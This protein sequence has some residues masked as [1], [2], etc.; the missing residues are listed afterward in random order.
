M[1]LDIFFKGWY[2]EQNSGKEN[3]P[4]Q[5]ILFGTKSRVGNGNLFRKNSAELVSERFSLFHGI[6]C[7]FRGIP[8]SGKGPIPKLGTERNGIPRKK[9]VYTTAENLINKMICPYMGKSCFSYTIFWN[10]WLPR[11]V[12][13]G[14]SCTE[15]IG[16]GIPRVCFFFVSMEFRVLFS[17]AEWF[18]TE[19]GKSIFAP[20]NEI[21][22]C[23]FF[24]RRVQDGIKGGCFY[25]CSLERN[26]ESFRF[27]VTSSIPSE[28]TICSVYFVF[29][30]IIFL[31][32]ISNST[33]CI[34]T[35]VTTVYCYFNNYFQLC[36]VD[37]GYFLPL[38][39]RHPI[40]TICIVI[41]ILIHCLVSKFYHQF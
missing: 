25:F 41:F 9:L 11:F 12:S 20:Q 39:E 7:S 30:G 1:S 21:P 31:S 23:F 26:S 16:N 19:F 13:V 3:L 28:I 40:Q 10:F 35:Q 4:K 15:W 27:R 22:S 2:H 32:E 29:R 17:S 37:K 14:F 38:V 36:H 18:W 6:K 33:K 8:S 24:R 5:K 34:F